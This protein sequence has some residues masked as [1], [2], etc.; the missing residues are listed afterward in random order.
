[1]I[2]MN[3]HKDF[4]LDGKR[5]I[6]QVVEIE[7]QVLLLFILASNTRVFVNSDGRK[8]SVIM[9]CTSVVRGERSL[10]AWDALV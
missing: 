2:N 9:G 5:R 1:M 10:L 7:R 6:A 8:K 4:C 3:V